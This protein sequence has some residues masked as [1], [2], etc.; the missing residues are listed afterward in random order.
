MMERRMECGVVIMNGCIYVIGGYFYLKGM[1]FQ[2]IEKYDLDFNKWE[3]WV[4][5]L[6]LCG[7]MGVF[8]CIMFN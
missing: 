3:Q 4:I 2:S 1:Y 5:F 8:V 7:F 6:V